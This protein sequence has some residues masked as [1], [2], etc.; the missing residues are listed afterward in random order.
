MRRFSVAAALVLALAG[1]SLA[2]AGGGNEVVATASGA[3]HFTLHN[4]FGLSTLEVRA[5]V[6]HARQKENGTADGGWFYSD[7]ED[8]A[9]WTTFGAVTCVTIRGNHAWVGGTIAYSSDPSVPRGRD[10]WF[11]VIDNGGRGEPPDITTLVGVG[12]TGQAKA[13]CD[14]A[15]PPRFPWPVEHSQGEIVVRPADH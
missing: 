3:S 9:P 7:V 8:G 2:T 1:A 14:A 4:V 6:F 11:Q 10:L 13:Y 12:L 5:F 15:N